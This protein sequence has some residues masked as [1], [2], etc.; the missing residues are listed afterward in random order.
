MTMN[1]A[2]ALA[3]VLCLTVTSSQ[4]G[5]GENNSA[6]PISELSFAT[7][8][9]NV[10]SFVKNDT[11]LVKL[12]NNESESIEVRV[13]FGDSEEKIYQNRW[14]IQLTEEEIDLLAKILWVEARGESDGGQQAVV[15]VIFNR[16]VSEEFPSTLYD[17][18]SQKKPVQFASWKL[19]DT[20]EPT[21]REYATIYAVLNGNTNIVRE[22]TLYF[23]TK[24]LTRNLD[25]KIGGH[26]FCY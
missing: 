3:L 6:L 9:E 2:G 8:K 1:V 19:R 16:I 7:E 13:N 25:I 10:V 5:L 23:A 14:G 11:N 12:Y 20:A 18:L 24:K 26:Y 22:D 21:E 4:Q 17:V 15:E